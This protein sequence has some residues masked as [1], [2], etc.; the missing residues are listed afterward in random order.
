M[1]IETPLG[2]VSPLECDQ[3]GHMNVQFYVAKVSDRDIKKAKEG[4]KEPDPI[5]MHPG[6]RIGKQGIE[7]AFDKE[8]R[9]VPGGQKVEVDLPGAE[10]VITLPDNGRGDR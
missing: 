9:G 10:I 8:L 3:L 7:K 5:L 1:F 4:G 2:R 6:F